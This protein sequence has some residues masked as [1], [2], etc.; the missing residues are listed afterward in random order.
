MSKFE[1]LKK[2]GLELLEKVEKME[3]LE[4]IRIE[5]L[6]KK[7]A[8]QGLMSE[9]KNV[10]AEER[11]LFGKSVNELKNFFETLVSEKMVE[12][13]EKEIEKRLEDEKIDISL[14]GVK[15]TN[16][17]L[18]PLTYVLQEMEDLFVS[19]GYSVVEGPEVE[20]D[21]YNFERANIPQ[22]H[23]ARDMQ[24]T[25]FVDVERLLR[26]HTTAIQTRTLE[27]EASNLPIKVICPGKTYRRDDD[28]ATHSHQFMQLEGLVVAENIT[29]G[30]LKGTLELIAKRMFGEKRTIRLRPS[31]FQF[32]EPSM[33]V[34]VSCFSC[35]GS[36]CSICKGSGWIEVLGSGMVHPKVLEMAGIDSTKYSGFAFGIGMERVAMLKYGIDDI[37]NFYINDIRFLDMFKRFE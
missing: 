16:R 5:F 29:L 15:S 31:Y 28:D 24:D 14:P 10:S 7:G 25:F 3:D 32:T 1:E 6:G 12:M 26:T 22:G 27:N 18:H 36:G 13:T 8:I 9:M 2:K 35:G 33:E 34:D 23:P 30:D 37:R 11:P 17:N 19:Q 21:L 4:K 20:L